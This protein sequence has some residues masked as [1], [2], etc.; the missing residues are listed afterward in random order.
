K[1]FY[2]DLQIDMTD[3]TKPS[4]LPVGARVIYQPDML[5]KNLLVQ[6][7]GPSDD[8]CISSVSGGLLEINPFTGAPVKSEL[9]KTGENSAG[10]WGEGGWGDII[11]Q[12]KIAYI[13]GTGP[14]EILGGGRL[15][16]GRQSWRQ[17]R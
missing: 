12:D 8:P 14:L 4:P 6:M 11:V 13:P 9:Y 17:I 15:P 3:A 16:G 5:K 1:G 10:L 7:I 2:I